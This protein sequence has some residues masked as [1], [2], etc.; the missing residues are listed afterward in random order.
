MANTDKTPY[1]ILGVP[2]DMSYGELRT[3]YRTK[4]HEHKQNKISP[5]NFRR[6]CRAYE[7]VSDFDK[8]GHYDSH[9]EWISDVPIDKYTLQQLAAEPDL[10]RYLKIQIENAHLDKINAQDPGTSHTALYCA[11][12]AGN[13]EAVKLLI[14]RGAESD[15]SQRTKSTA[16]HAASYFGHADVV[17]FLLESGADY[18][19]ANNSNSTAE[20]EAY[21]NDVKEVFVELKQNP[22]VRVA[23]DELEWFH[24]NPLTEHIDTEYFAQRQTLLHCACKKGYFDMVRWLVVEHSANVD[25]VDFNGNSPLHLAVYG[26]HLDIVEYLL[27]RGCNP[28][29]RNRWG[30]TAEEE[31]IKHGR[32]IADLFQSMRQRDIFEMAKTGIDWWFY[33]YFDVQSK[34]MV[35]SNGISLLYHACRCGQYSVAKWLL[36]H[37]ANVNIQMITKPKSTP[38]HGAKYR[39]HLFIVELLLEYGA[40]VNIKND[41][42]ATV[43]DEAISDEVDN[44]LSSRIN[45][46]L[47]QHQ[48]Y[49]KS[50]KL[51]DVEIYLHESDEDKPVVKFQIDHKSVYDDLWQALPKNLWDKKYYF[52]IAGRPLNFQETNTRIMSAVYCAR[53]TNSKLVDTPLRLTLHQTSLNDTYH[54]DTR[55][56]VQ[57]GPRQVASMFNK[58]EKTSSFVLKFPFTDRGTFNNGD[59]T[60]TFSTNCVQDDVTFEVTRLNSSNPGNHGLPN[61]VCFFKT[62]LSNTKKSDALLSLPLVS[63]VHQPDARLYTLAMP[64]SYWFSSDTRQNQLPILGGIHAFIRHVDIIPK[65]LTLPADIFIAGI[66]GQ[67]LTERNNPISCKCL[68]LRKQ[69]T[70]KFPHIAY[71]GTNINVIRS[72]LLDSLV[73]PGT[74]VSS[75][76]RINPPENH[77]ARKLPA[78]GIIDFAA[79]IFLSP[80]VWYSSDAAYAIDFTHGDQQLI[81]VLECSVKRNS[82]TTNQCTTPTYTAHPSDNL[83]AIEWRVKDPMNIEINAI[84]F[85]TKIDSILASRMARMATITP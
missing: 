17:R 21:G 23:A 42:G 66:F 71:H 72:I 59:L 62:S 54:Q 48:R 37:G 1:D 13:V 47:L 53:Y 2:K 79:A 45:A 39:G 14:G 15:I 9:T 60:F 24:E 52:T 10:L 73:A 67:P 36:E 65:L 63:I 68:T 61:A 55:E 25:L 6:I 33:Y 44:D 82:F 50:H 70:D 34:D 16:L 32:W 30:T 18:R 49:L 35:D 7:T 19:I 41:F 27:N 84:L 46:I 77:I 40:D 20:E 76:K 57:I 58:E 75:G 51:I 43:F 28:H 12:R 29:F 38:L 80:S 5:I 3:V 8:R 85:I 11:A 74:V 64:S 56:D 81:P 31:G 4:I 78:Y 26:G 22:Y 69:D 83:E